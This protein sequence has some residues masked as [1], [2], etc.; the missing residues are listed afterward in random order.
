MVIHVRKSENLFAIIASLLI[1]YV[2]LFNFV[3]Y[4]SYDNKVNAYCA[5]NELMLII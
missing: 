2:Y 3:S 1:T 5:L 4:V